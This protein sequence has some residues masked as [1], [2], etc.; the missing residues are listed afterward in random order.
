MA[1]KIKILDSSNFN[2]DIVLSGTTYNI[3]VKYNPSDKSWYLSI[4]DSANTAIVTGIKIMPNQNL[5]Y[6][7]KYLNIFTDG[8][9]WC[10]RL[11]AV[12]DPLGRDNFG[13]GKAYELVWISSEDAIQEEIEGVIQL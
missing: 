1:K 5:T 9:L 4:R 2:T 10:L 8:D 3:L 11:K 12:K 13:I 7:L 6:Q